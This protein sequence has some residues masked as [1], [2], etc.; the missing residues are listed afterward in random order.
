MTGLVGGED[1]LFVQDQQSDLGM[2]AEEL[3]G[4]GQTQDPGPHDDDVVDVVRWVVWRSGGRQ[5]S[6]GCCPYSVWLLPAPIVKK[7]AMN[8]MVSTTIPV[9]SPTVGWRPERPGGPCHADRSPWIL[10][11]MES[12]YSNNA[13]LPQHWSPGRRIEIRTMG[14]V[15]PG[16][17]SGLLLIA[18]GEGTHVMKTLK[19]GIGTYLRNGERH[20]VAA[21]D[22]LLLQT[23]RGFVLDLS[24][25]VS[26]EL[27]EK[28]CLSHA[29]T[30]SRARY[31][32][33][34]QNSGR[35]AAGWRAGG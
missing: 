32:R 4:S 23:M 1:W 6:A 2:P 8:G 5:R 28:L 19:L 26:T 34:E 25:H 31:I 7:D 24:D 12:D 33:H 30:D 16:S 15:F 18:H 20:N 17:R 35:V 21:I 22:S 14:N 9:V 13:D 29:A 11:R 3:T 10:H 27:T